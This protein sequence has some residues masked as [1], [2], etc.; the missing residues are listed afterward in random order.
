M[1][2]ADIFGWATGAG[3]LSELDLCGWRRPFNSKAC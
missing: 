1:I 3:S 2:G